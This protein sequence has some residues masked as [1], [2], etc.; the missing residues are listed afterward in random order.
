MRK[1]KTQFELG[2]ELAIRQCRSPLLPEVKIE[3]AQVWRARGPREEL[4]FA[5][6]NALVR[7]LVCDRDLSLVQV[8][9]RGSSVHTR[10]RSKGFKWRLL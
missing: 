6:E 1:R 3:W 9:L 10:V 2:L 5:L 4:D 7:W 8:V